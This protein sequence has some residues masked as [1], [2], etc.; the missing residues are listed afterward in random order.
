MTCECKTAEAERESIIES[1]MQFGTKEYDELLDNPMGQAHW[2][3][4]EGISAVI[5]LIKGDE[6][7]DSRA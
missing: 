5:K 1:M 3:Y 4:L 7:N 6:K 2:A